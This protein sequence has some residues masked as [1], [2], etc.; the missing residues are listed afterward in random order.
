VAAIDNELPP[1]GRC[2][3]C[4]QLPFNPD[5]AQHIYLDLGANRGDT[6]RLFLKDPTLPPLNELN[7]PHEYKFLYN[8]AKFRVVAVEA[9]RE[10]H[11]SSLEAIQQR[12][13]QVEIIYAAA[14]TE[15]GATLRIYRDEKAAS[16]GEWGAGMNA[17]F[18]K[19]FTD[20]R[21]LDISS[22]LAAQVCPCDFVVAK[23]N[24]EGA[25]FAVLDKM[26]RDRT[27][28]LI[29]VIHAYFHATFFPTEQ[30]EG[31]HQKVFIY[32]RAFADCGTVAE[33]W[34]AHR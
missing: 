34:R 25:E 17:L 2:G 19:N 29:D 9:L 16:H 13:P 8:P 21:T 3:Y 18:S 32:N 10:L 11:A 14:G 23:I 30:R 22:W 12:Y 27:L 26:M 15:D 6:L 20:V 4:S 24:I 28:C 1:Q 7:N 5:T 31:Y 33:E